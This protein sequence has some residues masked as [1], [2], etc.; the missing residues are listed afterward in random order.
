MT[1]YVENDKNN[2]QRDFSCLCSTS[3]QDLG[4]PWDLIIKVAGF[5]K[6]TR[7]IALAYE[8]INLQGLAIFSGGASCAAATTSAATQEALVEAA[9]KAKSLGFFRILFLCS[10]SSIVQA[11]NSK[12][13]NRWQEKTMVVDLIALQQQGLICKALCV[14]RAILS[15]VYCIADLAANIPRHHS[16]IHP[17]IL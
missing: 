5:R 13:S 1:G 7:R 2:K 16:W 15:L 17:D 9:L 12:C 4:G 10:N 8:A 11:C 3:W 14:P 6:R